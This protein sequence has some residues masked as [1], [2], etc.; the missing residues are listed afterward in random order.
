MIKKKKIIFVH[1]YGLGAPLAP[2]DWPSWL[3][4]EVKKYGFDF[5]L[6]LMPDPVYPEVNEWLTFLEKQK[7]KVDNDTY[8]VGHSLGCITIAR[9]L[10]KLPLKNI[11]GGCI[12]ISG[13]CSLPQLPLLAVFCD[14]PLDYAKV[15][16][17]AKEFV[18]IISD[19]DHIIPPA[20]SK[21]LGDKLGARIIMEHGQGHFTTGIKKIPSLLNI[22]LEMTQMKEELTE[23]K[24][25]NYV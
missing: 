3:A 16:K 8:F 5:Q 25:L 17:Q 20:S 10:E 11:A 18:M 24:K 21:E 4:Q 23:M 6:L 14:L 19:D 13:F 7:I 12:F 15:K 9:F 2:D 22:I 1:G